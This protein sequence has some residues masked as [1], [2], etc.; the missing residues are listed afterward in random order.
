MHQL[1][2]PRRYKERSNNCFVVMYYSYHYAVFPGFTLCTF[3]LLFGK[4]KAQTCLVN[5]S[6]WAE[7]EKLVNSL[8]I[9]ICKGG[10]SSLQGTRPVYSFRM[11]VVLQVRVFKHFMLWWYGSEVVPQSSTGSCTSDI[12]TGYFYHKIK[13]HCPGIEPGTSAWKADILPLN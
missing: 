6:F 2:R 11:N 1:S 5:G 3:F 9:M 7:V 8:Y 10:I 12:Q 13:M 4:N